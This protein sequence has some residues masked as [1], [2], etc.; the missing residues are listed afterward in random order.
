MSTLEEVL[1]ESLDQHCSHK[2]LFALC[3]DVAADV[4]ASGHVVEADDLAGDAELMQRVA[5]IQFGD[6]R[7]EA[8]REAGARIVAE[9]VQSLAIALRERES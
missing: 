9:Y 5:Q 7:S 6:M 3:V 1:H 2:G 4:R 8:A